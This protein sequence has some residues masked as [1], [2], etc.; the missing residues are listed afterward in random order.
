MRPEIMDTDN[1]GFGR[2]FT[3]HMFTIKYNEEK[4]WHDA[5][6]EKYGPLPLDP[7]A[8]VLHYS[9]EIFEGLKAYAAEDGRVLLFRPAENVKR[10]NNSA[11]RLCMPELPE[12]IFLEA[13]QELVMREKDWIP[14][15]PGTSLYIRPAMLGSEPFLGV[16]SSKEFLFYIILSPVGA[17]FADGFKP[18]GIYV[19]DH[20]SR[21]AR[22]GVGDIKTG[23]NYAAS[24]LAGLEAKKKGFSQVLWLDDAE[25]KY[26][27]E[28]GAMNIFFV[29]GQELLTPALNGSI[30]P[31]ITRAS[32]ITLAEDMG[33]PVQ[34]S[35]LPIEEILA[36]IA[37]G[38]I[39]EA[40][41]AGTAAVLAP[42]GQLNYQDRDYVVGGNRVGDVTNTIYERLVNIQYGR[43]DDKFKWVHEVGRFEEKRG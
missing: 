25:H 38:E 22:G 20:R 43:A 5:R 40:F 33:Y 17:Y 16:R 14:R 32:V 18:I 13:L 9:Q 41:G 21:A 8:G 10:L 39:T 23:G 36:G 15:A 1:L 30:L 24:L 34:E 7:A 4:G 26:V 19:E 37:C 12:E 6:V 42:V 3:D 2:I 28:V 29:R 11:R 35:P 31:G 27:E